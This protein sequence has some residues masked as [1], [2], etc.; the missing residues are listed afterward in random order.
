[1]SITFV[2]TANGI[3]ASD[4]NVSFDHNNGGDTLIAVFASVAASGDFTDPSIASSILT[5]LLGNTWNLVYSTVNAVSSVWANY[6]AIAIYV[7]QRCIDSGLGV[8]LAMPTEL[9]PVD[10]AASWSNGVEFYT[11]FANIVLNVANYLNDVTSNIPYDM[12]VGPTAQEDILIACAFNYDLVAGVEP[13]FENISA[14]GYTFTRLPMLGTLSSFASW[15]FD[16]SKNSTAVLRNTFPAVVNFF[17]GVF[18]LSGSNPQGKSSTA[19]LVFSINKGPNPV[20]LPEG[21]AI[22]TVQ[23]DCTQQPIVLP[24][25]DYPEYAYY[26]NGASNPYGF[27]VCEFDLEHLFQGSGLSEVRTIMAFSRP[28]FNYDGVHRQDLPNSDETAY[29]FAAMIT[30]KVT[31]QTIMLGIN[32]AQNSGPGVNDSSYLIMPYPGNK[33]GLKYRFIAPQYSDVPFGKY[34]LQFLNF[35]VHGACDS[36]GATNALSS[37]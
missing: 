20:V 31:L 16:A 14:P 29:M 26:P 1:M 22:A 2:R 33:G 36:I 23:I 18:S 3:G 17:G 9:Q 11:T 10:V 13:Y 32:P 5:D 19:A 27:V 28:G 30:N 35:E 6:S 7:C 21:R 34:I 4:T 24:P 37:T 8:Q 15:A 12:T 25:I